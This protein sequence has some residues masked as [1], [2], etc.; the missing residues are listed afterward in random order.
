MEDAEAVPRLWKVGVGRVKELR[1]GKSAEEV[2]EGKAAAVWSMACVGG[3]H[4]GH[5]D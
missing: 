4:L 1:V 5:A 3:S 2:L